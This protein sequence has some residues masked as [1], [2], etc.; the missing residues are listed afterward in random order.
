MILAFF[1]Q[2]APSGGAKY[3]CA[4]VLTT[5]SDMLNADC[6]TALNTGQLNGVVQS[7]AA[8]AL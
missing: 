7:S 5:A 2:A 3:A 1:T 4:G 8:S 6:C